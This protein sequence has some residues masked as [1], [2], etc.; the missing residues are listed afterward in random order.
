MN[1]SMKET[2]HPAALRTLPVLGSGNVSTPPSEAAA[3]LQQPTATCPLHHAESNDKNTKYPR[4]DRKKEKEQ[5]KRHAP[6]ALS[7]GCITHLASARLRRRVDALIRQQR[8]SVGHVASGDV[9][10]NDDRRGAAADMGHGQC[11]R[12]W[13]RR[14]ASD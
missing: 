4:K 11:D 10:W 7:S 1:E 5:R 3:L 12:V 9:V 13:G 14:Q 6:Q 8:R 2:R